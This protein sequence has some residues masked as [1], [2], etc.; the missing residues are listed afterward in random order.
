MG[1]VDSDPAKFIGIGRL[2]RPEFSR[3]SEI[4]LCLTGANFV[5]RFGSFKHTQNSPIAFLK[6]SADDPVAP[7]FRI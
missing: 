1:L 2:V 3:L 4:G 7:S 5:A 6:S